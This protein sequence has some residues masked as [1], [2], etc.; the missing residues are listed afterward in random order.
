[1]KVYCL[2]IAF[3]L[4]A[5]RSIRAQEVIINPG[6][7]FLPA[8]IQDSLPAITTPGHILFNLSNNRPEIFTQNFIWEGFNSDRL[9]DNDRDTEILLNEGT[10]DNI[11]FRTDNT[12][13]LT[14]S[15][16]A[17]G[18]ANLILNGNNNTHIGASAGRDAITAANNI[19]IGSSALANNK[20]GSYNI[21]I[22]SDALKNMNTQEGQTQ[23]GKQNI[24]IGP[25]ALENADGFSGEN[26]AVGYE[27]GA[28]GGSQS[29]F[30]GYQAG[31]DASE[32]SNALYINN[33]SG[34]NPLIFGD[35]SQKSVGI[36]YNGN[37]L[38]DALHI[39]S[40]EEQHPLRVRVNGVTRFRVYNNGGATI[41]ENSTPAPE[42]LKVRNLRSEESTGPLFADTGGNLTRESNLLWHMVGPSEFRADDWNGLEFRMRDHLIDLPAIYPNKPYQIF[43]PVHLPDGVIIKEV[44]ITYK[45]NSEATLGIRLGHW[46]PLSTTSPTSIISFYSNS[47]SSLKRQAFFSD[48]N[49]KVENQD[50][51]YYVYARNEEN[52]FGFGS[53]AQI[54]GVAIGYKYE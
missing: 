33:T 23:F 52:E 49:V 39:E 2:L 8:L 7:V 13:R 37:N 1:M 53:D 17:A 18:I 12:K 42:G 46:S 20:A 11:E 27:A 38:G 29:V 19:A 50:N 45:D 14:I 25:K 10:Q 16:N 22:G 41:G 51:R 4:F 35:F 34:D 44:I 28:S 43:A 32:L 6:G 5:T 26:V 48:I 36:N 31:K 54:Y 9:I 3:I 47:E 24:A 30:L 21:A 40:G 15:S